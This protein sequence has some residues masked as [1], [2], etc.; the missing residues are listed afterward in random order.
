MYYAAVSDDGMTLT[1]DPPVEYEHISIEQTIDGVY[2]ETRAEVGL[3]TR[4]V[5]VRGS[6]HSEWT[7][8]IEA[9]DA[10]FDTSKCNSIAFLFAF[11]TGK[12]V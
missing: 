9:C 6:V 8:T 4:N 2:L 7:E 11:I 10:E 12:N 3:L 1:F 5:V